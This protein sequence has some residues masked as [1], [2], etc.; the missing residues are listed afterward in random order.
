MD[1]TLLIKDILDKGGAVNLFTRPRRFGKTLALTMLRTFFEQERDISGQIKDNAHYFDGMKIMDAGEAYT[2]HMGQYPV[3]FL[4][5]K[6]AKQPS[7][8]M[9]YKS[10]LDEICR[11]FVRHRY[12]LDGGL[13]ENYKQ[14]YVEQMNRKANM[15]AYAK[16]LGFLSECLELYHGRKVII[17]MDEYDVP[18]ENSFFRG[19]YDEMTDFIRSLF[20][21][22]LKTN[23][24]LEFAVI[25]GCLRISKES[26]FTGLNNLK[27]VSILNNL[28][29][30]YYGFTQ[31]EVEDMLD[32]YGIGEK[33]DEVK[34]WYDGYLFGNTEVY[35]PWSVIN[36][37]DTAIS[38][39]FSFPRPYWSNTSSNSIVK[40]LVETAD[41]AVKNEIENLIAGGTIEKPVHEDITYG[42][43]HQSQDN[44][45]NFLFFTGYL[46]KIRERGEERTIYLTLTI[47]NEEILSIYENT[48]LDWFQQKI[49]V[50]DFKPMYQALLDGDSVTVEEMIRQQLRECISYYDNEERFYHGFLLGLLGAL[51]EYRIV[52]NRESGNGRP[53]ILLIPYDERK[54]AVVLELKWTKNLNEMDSL[55]E[56]AL[57]QAEEQ[58]Y[59]EGLA[60]EGYHK[61]LKYGIC[62]CKKSCRV[63]KGM[64]IG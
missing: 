11:E 25:T 50:F 14:Q 17:L 39:G 2:K 42:D 35:N 46:K 23:D 43:I 48:I 37:V 13:P 8:E 58:R 55:C 5:L 7:F 24:S 56:E 32:Y 26:V 47:P 59:A 51:R 31:T 36:Y 21:S 22:A 29:A 19:F 38:G 1:K 4:S 16:S 27:V 64:D 52:S 53:D 10:L 57:R 34:Q 60:E 62:F 18:L 15:S 63:K 40:E 20:E 49:K 33:T 30:E 12:V 61:V 45:W 3:I 28:F 44:L 54:Y 6:S 9:A 41:D